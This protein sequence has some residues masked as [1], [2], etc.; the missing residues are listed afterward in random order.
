MSVIE[1]A[2]RDRMDDLKR[3]EAAGEITTEEY[4]GWVKRYVQVQKPTPL[5]QLK[6]NVLKARFQIRKQCI[7]S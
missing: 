2:I 4:D 7:P 3:L 5:D 1:D 6:E